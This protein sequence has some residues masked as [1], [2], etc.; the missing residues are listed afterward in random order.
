[1][2]RRRAYVNYL[3]S[4]LRSYTL[5]PSLQPLLAFPDTDGTCTSRASVRHRTYRDMPPTVAWFL[6]TNLQAEG[7]N[8]AAYERL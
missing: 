3:S 1:M 5:P 6:S 4:R 2:E 7:R 8:K